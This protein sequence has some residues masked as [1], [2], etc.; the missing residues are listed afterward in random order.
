MLTHQGSPPPGQGHRQNRIR[1]ATRTATPTS[2]FFILFLARS[3]FFFFMGGRLHALPPITQ[4]GRGLT[5]HMD[6]SAETLGGTTPPA[7]RFDFKVQIL[8]KKTFKNHC[9]TVILWW[10]IKKKKQQRETPV[11]G[12]GEEKQMKLKRFPNFQ[13]PFEKK[14][15]VDMACF[16]VIKSDIPLLYAPSG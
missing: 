8:K 1:I 7:T 9:V 6:R 13:F 12:W 5:N 14:T 11:L 10:H 2:T 16:S 15:Y 4:I 3:F